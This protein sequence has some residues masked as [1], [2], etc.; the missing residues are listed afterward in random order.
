MAGYEEGSNPLRT[1]RVYVA[2]GNRVASPVQ[3]PRIEIVCGRDQVSAGVSITFY[4]T[5]ED[6]TLLEDV[7]LDK[8]F[9]DAPMTAYEC[10][11]VA[12]RA[13]GWHLAQEGA[14]PS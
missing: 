13:L 6:G 4:G 5:R 1:L 11:D 10:L 9:R 14:L 7:M 12:Y 3:V 8:R 2:T